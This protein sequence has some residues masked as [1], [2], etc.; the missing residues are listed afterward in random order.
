MLRAW[1]V[2][3]GEGF[4]TADHVQQDKVDLAGT[5]GAVHI[6]AVGLKM[7]LMAEPADSLSGGGGGKLGYYTH[8]VFSLSVITLLY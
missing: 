4:L 5:L 1:Q 3:S 7:Q 8:G 6:G 2:T